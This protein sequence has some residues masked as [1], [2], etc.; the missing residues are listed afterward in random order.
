[1]IRKEERREQRVLVIDIRYRKQDGTRGRYRH[2][3]Q[4]QTMAAATAEERRILANITQHGEPF[5][6]KPKAPEQDP[7]PT[8]SVTFRDA[9]EVFQRTTAITR[10]KPS[11][12]I[13]YD[14][15]FATRLLPRFGDQPID[16]VGLDAMTELDAGMV[17]EGLS[18]SRRRNVLICIRSVLRAAHEG[19]RLARLPTFAPLPKKGRKVLV[20][21]TRDQVESILDASP[22]AWRLAFGIAAYAGLRAGE[23][24]ALRWIDV[25]RDATLLVVRDSQSKGETSTPKSG[26]EREVPIA[27]PLLVVIEAVGPKAGRELVATTGRGA[28]W[29]ES[30]LLQA[31][32]RAQGKA[33]IE[34]FRFHDLRHFFVTELFRRGGSAPAVQLLAGHLH[35]TTT[36]RYAHLVRSD[37]RATIG[38]FAGRGNSG[39]TGS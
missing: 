2:D 6:P 14:E 9:V 32:R 30:G 20:P 22:S 23:V 36:Q 25:D 27:E 24:R 28:P 16:R 33:G 11:T 1:M 12:R 5:E 17:K 19:G 29:G 7:T 3:A 18:A 15:I 31:F 10:L 8:A 39:A 38:L 21:L 26:H 35:L 34:G 4:V 13:G 37:L